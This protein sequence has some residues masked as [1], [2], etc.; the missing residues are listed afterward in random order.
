MRD[1]E[2]TEEHD[3]LANGPT[4]QHEEQ[5]DADHGDPYGLGTVEKAPPMPHRAASVMTAEQLVAELAR[6]V[7]ML[8]PKGEWID[9]YAAQRVRP[10]LAAA[11]TKEQSTIPTYLGQGRSEDGLGLYRFASGQPYT[12]SR[13][14][15][16]RAFQ[17]LHR[18]GH[19]MDAVA[20]EVGYLD[21]AA[22]AETIKALRKHDSFPPPVGRKKA[23]RK[24]APA[25][26]AAAKPRTVTPEEAAE[27]KR[28]HDRDLERM[29]QEANEAGPDAVPDEDGSEPAEEDQDLD[30]LLAEGGART[31]AHE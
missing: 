17:W 31:V 27:R 22:L 10:A 6:A 30:L 5:A 13:E 2:Q 8:A 29:L 26:P 24:V 28:E 19:D 15:A 23:K 16:V 18:H 20:V 1:Y 3:P 9:R 7:L 21:A 12:P 4:N 14:N 11:Y 25:T